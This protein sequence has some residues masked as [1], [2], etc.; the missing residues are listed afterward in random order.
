MAIWS[1]LNEQN[2]GGISG[3]IGA[4]LRSDL[5][6]QREQYCNSEGWPK[7]TRVEV[8]SACV[9]EMD[10]A[11]AK[12]FA[13]GEDHIFLNQIKTLPKYQGKGAGA[14]LMKWGTD[15]A[16]GERLPIRLESSPAGRSLYLKS[17]FEILAEVNHDVSRFGGPSSYAHA[18]MVRRPELGS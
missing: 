10:K 12:H 9:P 13:A 7:E 3:E 18:L 16:D 5:Q 2:S 8:V 15:L 6:R 11:R 1:R 4:E 14:M 17:G